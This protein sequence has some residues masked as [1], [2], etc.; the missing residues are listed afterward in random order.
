[1]TPE[2]IAFVLTALAAVVVVLTR[3]RFAS[4]EE[5]AAG[6]LDI[7]R[8]VVNV[9]TIFGVLALAGWGAFLLADVRTW[10]GYAGLACWWVTT[11]AGLLI[12]MRWLPARG[13]HASGPA[14]DS[15]GE[16]PGLSVL[17]HVGLLV[18]SVVWTYLL[19]SG[20]LT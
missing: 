4:G 10:V 20:K 9:H 11:A 2:R 1:M 3:L 13:R 15:W 18:G 16:G 14:S 6:R 19:V 12:L 17:G 7:S 5:E 8:S